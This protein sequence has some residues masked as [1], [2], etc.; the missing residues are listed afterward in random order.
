MLLPSVTSTT[1][2]FFANSGSS[3]SLVPG[4]SSGFGTSGVGSTGIGLGS[5]STG[6]DLAT[7]AGLFLEIIGGLIALS[8]VG[9]LVIIV[10]ANRADPDPTGRRPQSVYY[11]VVSFVTLLLA[12]WGSALAVIGVVALVGNHS[13]AVSNS[14]AKAILLGALL[15][16]VS[17]FLFSTHVRRGL[18]NARTD[19]QPASPSRRVGQSYVASVAFVSIVSFFIL[20]VFSVYLIFALAAPGVF[21]SFGSQGNTA[22]VLIVAIYLVAVALAIWETHRK[23]VTPE[24]DLLG[25]RPAAVAPGGASQ[26]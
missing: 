12:V 21:G 15:T 18:Q 20:F 23:L 13:S 19:E 11:F 25:G 6:F 22:R 8:L 17:V 2:P 3:G 10:V 16:V 7:F 4:G 5:S 14:S 24:L 9:V 1:L 26:P